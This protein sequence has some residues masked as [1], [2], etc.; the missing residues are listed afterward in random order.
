MDKGGGKAT[1]G[2]ESYNLNDGDA[3]I[4]PAG[5]KHNVIANKKGLKLYVVYAP[6]EHKED[7]VQE[8]KPE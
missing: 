5:V 8:T 3:I 1:I 6:P 4:I 2:E 7:T